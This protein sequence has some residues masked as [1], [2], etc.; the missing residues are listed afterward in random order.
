MKK[1]LLTLMITAVAMFAVSCGKDNKGSL[2]TTSSGT[3]HTGNVSAAE[4][5]TAPPQEPV[6]AVQ[7]NVNKPAIE[8]NEDITAQITQEAFPYKTDGGELQINS[9]TKVDGYFVE[10]G[11]N[12]QASNVLAAEF[13]NISGNDIYFARVEMTSDKGESV[14]FI[15]S[16][17]KAGEK[18]LVQERNAREYIEDEQLTFASVSAQFAESAWAENLSEVLDIKTGSGDNGNQAM[19]TNNS[20]KYVTGYIYY[21]QKQDDIIHGGITYRMK[22]ESP[23]KPGETASISAVHFNSNSIIVNSELELSENEG[24]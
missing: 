22:I 3:A 23:I 5:E 16:Y 1:I 18:V 2:S 4:A 7:E 21:K 24:E 11:S 6:N 19:I 10:D 8:K 14:I 17:I 20:D 12:A 13:E 9:I 15:M